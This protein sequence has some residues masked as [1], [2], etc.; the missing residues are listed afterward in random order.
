MPRIVLLALALSLPITTAAQDDSLARCAV[1]AD[2]QARLACFDALST[3]ASA[4]VPVATPA[5][6]P[7][8][9]FG[10]EN[11]PQRR[12]QAPAAGHIESRLVG[13]FDGWQQNTEFVLE[14]GQVWRCSDCR[15]VHY[16]S[17]E[18]P[19]VTIRRSFTGVYWLKVEGFKQQ[20]K[21][22][23]IR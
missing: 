18:A 20:A 17:V 1:I 11:L 22:R 15:I 3:T 10:A 19:S 13:R 2:A 4:Q 8:E 7:V 16:R 12:E 5:P 6:D 9:H 23:R 14:N 21:V